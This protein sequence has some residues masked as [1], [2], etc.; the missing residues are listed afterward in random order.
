MRSLPHLFLIASCLVFS[1]VWFTP[2]SLSLH[3]SPRFCPFI[4][5]LRL[6]PPPLPHPQLAPLVSPHLM[7][8]IICLSLQSLVVYHLYLLFLTSLLSSLCPI[9]T[10]TPICSYYCLSLSSSFFLSTSFQSLP[11]LYLPYKTLIIFPNSLIFFFVLP[12]LFLSFSCQAS[13][14]I[15]LCVI[16]R[17]SINPNLA[18]II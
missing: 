13:S 3:R 17:S 5:P 11:A 16:C 2:V 8:Y 6:A 7:P 10:I 1:L 14:S 9:S 18:Y 15:H 4:S 12:W